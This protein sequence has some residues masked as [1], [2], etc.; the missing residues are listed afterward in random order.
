ML[1]AVLI[2]FASVF[3]A[4]IAWRASLASIDSSRLQSLAVQDAARR[5][6]LERLIEGTVG[7]DERFVVVFQEHSRAARELAAQA[8]TLRES[9][10]DS[11]DILDLEAQAHAAIA[12]AMQPF[13]MGAGGI[14]LGDGGTVG[15]DREFVLESLRESD[16]ELGELSTQRTIDQAQQAD[17]R[18][19]SLIGVEAIII[20]A[21]FF[22]TV[23]QVS[24]SQIKVR[25]V[26][27]GIGGVLVAV[28]TVGFV[29]V[30]VLG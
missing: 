22:L 30:E 4:V 5:N 8:A 20:A 19:L 2:G 9:N 13:F 17:A 14:Q 12:R 15:Y 23:A 6:Q 1:L 3:S 24:R 28:G 11:A 7:Q 29:A 18:S 26:F 21:L 25:Q 27:F 16:I 10:P